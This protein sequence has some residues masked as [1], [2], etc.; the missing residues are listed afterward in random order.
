[1]GEA[2]HMAFEELSVSNSPLLML[3]KLN[4]LRFE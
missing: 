1:L 2:R 3:L 4:Y